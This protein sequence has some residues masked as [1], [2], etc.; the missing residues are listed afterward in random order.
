MFQD[1]N[2]DYLLLLSCWCFSLQAFETNQQRILTLLVQLVLFYI[3]AGYQCCFEAEPH[4]NETA[5]H[6]RDWAQAVWTIYSSDDCDRSQA[7]CAVI[8]STT[9][10][11]QF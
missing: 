5:E 11:L 1:A 7:A 2:V 8:N 6:T 10:P 3:R 4:W 9:E